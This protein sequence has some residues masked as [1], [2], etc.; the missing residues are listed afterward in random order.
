MIPMM[1][2]L[3][4]WQLHRYESAAA[5][6]T[7][8]ARNLQT[9]PVRYDTLVKPGHT[10]RE[11]NQWR[12]VTVTGHYDSGHEVVARLRT[13]DTGD[14]GFNVITPLVTED[15]HTV[16]VNRGWVPGR[17][18][19]N[20]YPKVPKTPSGAV[21]VTG[22]LRPSETEDNGGRKAH[23]GLPDRQV[24]QINSARLADRMP[25]TP[26]GGYLQLTTS[27]PKPGKGI[28]T[29]PG[30]DN[31]KTGLHIAYTAQWWLFAGMV[32]VAW[33]ILIRREAAERRDGPHQDQ[34]RGGS[35]QQQHGTGGASGAGRRTE[36]AESVESA[37]RTEP[38]GSTDSANG[39]ASGSRGG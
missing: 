12:N 22:R 2:W 14:V 28:Q 21:T 5:E 8:Q 15:G 4:F 18:A 13:N 31:A 24:T 34:A 19:P 25:G 6:N 32:P 27:T 16:L 39:L 33:V 38:I 7:L 11:K 37:D 17:Q 35:Q 36:P 3:G 30:P 29:L 1:I 10:V 26:L 20:S 23:S 9:K